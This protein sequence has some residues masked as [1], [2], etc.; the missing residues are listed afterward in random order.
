[1]LF[2]FLRLAMELL[3]LA[4]EISFKRISSKASRENSRTNWACITFSWIR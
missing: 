1:M 4:G 2:G 3:S